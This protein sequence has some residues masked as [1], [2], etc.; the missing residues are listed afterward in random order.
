MKTSR[1][2]FIAKSLITT[3][4]LS[5]GMSSW[6][7][8][9]ASTAHPHLSPIPT[10]PVPKDEAFK[11][12]V[13]SKNLQWLD[14]TQMAKVAAEIGFDGIDLTVRPLGH[15]Q[16]ERVQEDLPRAVEAIRK[17]GLDVYM[18]TTAITSVDEPYTE[19]IL[20]TA[21]SL[22]ITHYRMGWIN[23]DDTKTIEENLEVFQRQMSKLAALNKK[24]NITGDY[25]NHSGMFFGA[26]IWDLHA[27]LK[28]VNSPWIGSQYDIWHANVEG[29]NAWPI[30]LK[31]LSPYIKTI[32]IKDFQWAKKD[33]WVSESVPLGEGAI[34]FKLYFQLLKQFN[35]R[36]PI[37]MHYEY[38]LGGAEH[39]ATT[40]TIK[41]EDVIAAMKKDIATLKGFLAEIK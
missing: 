10:D 26:A 27:V 17:A 29:A 13:F 4:G 16:P 37:S 9:R 39:G 32:D 31:L 23:Y 3:V 18:I 11:I 28:K 41:K 35:V 14:Y 19:R 36:V 7:Q 12:S 5:S 40:L 8:A 38:S 34:N 6:M 33:K 15:V 24:Y 1:R 2:N 30:N 25:Q 20:Q 21:N 22:G